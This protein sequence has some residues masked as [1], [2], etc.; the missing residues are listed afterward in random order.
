MGVERLTWVLQL[1]AGR[2]KVQG[3]STWYYLLRYEHCYTTQYNIQQWVGDGIW[4]CSSGLQPRR[5][6]DTIIIKNTFITYIANRALSL[7]SRFLRI[8]IL[9]CSHPR[10]VGNET[11]FFFLLLLPKL[12][13]TWQCLLPWRMVGEMHGCHWAMIQQPAFSMSSSPSTPYSPLSWM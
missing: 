12:Y 10:F 1:V 13:T 3:W 9:I 7:K 8:N 5:P 6:R 11:Y 2:T 4:C